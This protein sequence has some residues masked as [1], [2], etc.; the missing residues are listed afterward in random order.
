MPE[1]KELDVDF[2]ESVLKVTVEGGALKQIEFDGGGSLRVVSRDVDASVRVTA[3]FAD[4][5]PGV[6]P[7]GARAVLLK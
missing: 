7:A 5:Q 4:R 3:R 6:I 2:S 1:L